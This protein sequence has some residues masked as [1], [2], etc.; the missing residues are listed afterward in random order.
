MCRGETAAA[1]LAVEHSLTLLLVALLI[2]D[3]LA[4][5]VVA[6]YKVSSAVVAAVEAVREG[7]TEIA[8]EAETPVLLVIQ[9]HLIAYRQQVGLPTQLWWLPAVKLMFH[10]QNNEQNR[11]EKTS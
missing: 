4:A 1:G 6:D 2:L 8:E 11:K 3:G 10:G 5:A 9:L 7:Q